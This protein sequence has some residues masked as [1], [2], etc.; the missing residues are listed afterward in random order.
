VARA[1]S[2]NKAQVNQ[3]IDIVFKMENA[4]FFDAETQSVIS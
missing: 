2:D 3:K 1:G 4:K